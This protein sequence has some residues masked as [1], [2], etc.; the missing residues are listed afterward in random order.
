[1]GNKE[2]MEGIRIVKDELLAPKITFDSNTVTVNED[3]KEQIRKKKKKVCPEQG[4]KILPRRR[5][6]QL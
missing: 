4:L 2:I 5:W 3:E 6:K 1:M